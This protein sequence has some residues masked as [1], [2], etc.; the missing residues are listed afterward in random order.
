MFVEEL[1][2]RVFEHP[3]VF[4]HRTGGAVGEDAH[5]MDSFKSLRAAAR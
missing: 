1:A 4:F 5:P 3:Q 2:H